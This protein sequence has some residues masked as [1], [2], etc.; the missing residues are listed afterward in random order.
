MAKSLCALMKLIDNNTV[1][2]RK[3]TEGSVC[4]QGL[5][6]FHHLAPGPYVTSHLESNFMR[7]VQQI[8]SQTSL[9]QLGQSTSTTKSLH[10]S[11]AE[12]QAFSMPPRMGTSDMKVN[13]ERRNRPG[14]KFGAK[15][16]SWV[17]TWFKQDVNNQNVAA[18]DLC[19]KIVI[20]LDSDKGSPKK[21]SEHLKTHKLTRESNNNKKLLPA[22][23][24]GDLYH[25]NCTVLDK[26][27]P[28]NPEIAS[29][30]HV[31]K[32]AD[33][34]CI[35]RP[36]QGFSHQTQPPLLQ[37][38]GKRQLPYQEPPK[39]YTQQCRQILPQLQSYHLSRVVDY[40]QPQPPFQYNSHQAQRQQ[41]ADGIL[42]TPEKDS[43][44]V[45][46]M[47]TMVTDRTKHSQD[48]RR[49]MSED[50]SS[51]GQSTSPY[52]TMR[53][54]KHLMGFLT[55][56]RLSINILESRSFQQLIYD[57]R[58]DSVADLLDLTQLYTSLLEVSRYDGHFK[59]IDEDTHP[60][61]K[62]NRNPGPSDLVSTGTRQNFR[63]S[64]EIS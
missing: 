19:G 15:K 1:Q 25:L 54:H 36:P 13:K 18:C 58:S 38:N 14:Q 3:L 53:F 21:L 30:F 44:E 41:L 62:K 28:C 63:L 47:V 26:V 48:G 17:W 61:D 9:G 34:T 32:T 27:N 50:L 56:N 55:E 4:S 8:T 29:C 60:T 43:Q 33:T 31:G 35:H 6:P 52:S 46:G 64:S 12:P 49:R 11:P 5:P 45:G 16:R 40:Q 39:E 20:R 7:L 57:L 24:D 2:S 37:L 42:Q 23:R 10:S 51:R 22:E 59:A